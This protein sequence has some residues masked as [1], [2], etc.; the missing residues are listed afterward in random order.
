MGIYLNPTYKNFEEN[1]NSEI[2]VDKTMMLAEL[3]KMIGTD[4]KYICLSRPRRFGKTIA[5]NMISAYYSKGNN[6]EKIFEK[7][8]ISK[9]PSYRDG[10]NK[11]NVIKIDVNSE[12]QNEKQKN[13][14][15]D[16]LSS[17][18]KNELIVAFQNVEISPD[19]S[20]AMCL[21]KI[22]D[23]TGEQF[24]VI[25]DEYDVLV[26]E[27]VSKELFDKYLGLLNGLFKSDTVRPALALAY[28]TGI[29]PVVRDK[30][31]SKLNNFTEYTIINA[32]NLAQYVGFTKEDVISLCQKYNM[33]YEECKRW[34]DGYRQMDI[35]L[36]NPQ[37]VTSAMCD[38]MYLNYW[39]QTSTYQAI[40]DRIR[41]NFVGTKEDVIKMIAG[42]SIDV[43]IT[44]YMNTMDSFATRGDIFTYLI[45]IGYLA[46]DIETG[47][48]RIPNREI[49]QE[50]HN[51]LEVEANYAVTTKIIQAS[52]ELLQAT[53]NGEE[54]VVAKALDESHIHVTS[55]RSYN[56]EDALQSAIYLSYIY[57]LNE[58]TVVRE[59]TAGKG[60]ADVVF[61]PFSKEKPAII[62]ELKR[63]TSAGN[64]L[65]QIKDKKYFECLSN[66][67][68][69]I[70]FVAINYD[71]NTKEHSCKIKRFEK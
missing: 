2:Y 31:Q 37:S 27:K 18:I 47:T 13:D 16:N 22:H 39:S 67:N 43:N 14:L 26:R 21:A 59:M 63:N 56:N 11:Y 54:D 48:C 32:R 5:G 24:V 35:E 61:I 66:Y 53:I 69:N 25:L 45:H 70:L 17:N 29:L 12:F 42:E 3:N 8:K 40:S 52:K 65:A 71:E 49:R 7:F 20:L 55:N 1:I 50:W 28:I 6:S 4:K 60:F 33:D 58:Y 57:A 36:Y 44:S 9:D 23:A 38:G 51:A 68:G 41:A 34:Y 62:I 19:D 15:I 10:L 30:V 64:A 46:Y